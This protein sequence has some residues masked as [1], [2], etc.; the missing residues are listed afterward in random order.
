MR[1]LGFIDFRK[2]KFFMHAVVHLV[3][4][5]SWRAW[6]TKPKL[7]ACEANTLPTSTQFERVLELPD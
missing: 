5:A 2:V 4:A 7:A 3:W 6:G 1:A